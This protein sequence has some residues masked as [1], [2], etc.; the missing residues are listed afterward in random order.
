ML[1]KLKCHDTSTS[2]KNHLGIEITVRFSHQVETCPVSRLRWVQK[3]EPNICVSTA[4]RDF[5]SMSLKSEY[6]SFSCQVGTA[7]PAKA[8]QFFSGHRSGCISKCFKKTVW[9]IPA[10]YMLDATV[11]KPASY[12]SDLDHPH[13]QELPKEAQQQAAEPLG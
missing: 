2:T 5:P 7:A 13:S 10:V 4:S 1:M 11:L 8:F 6:V 12:I 3:F 9:Y